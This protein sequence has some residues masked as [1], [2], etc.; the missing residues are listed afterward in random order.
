MGEA[1]WSLQYS[2]R[3]GLAGCL[4]LIFGYVLKF[5]TS[6][7]DQLSC[8]VVYSLLFTVIALLN[9]IA[10][11]RLWH[12]STRGEGEMMWS[13]FTSL[14]RNTILNE[15]LLQISYLLPL[16]HI[17]FVAFSL[18]NVMSRDTSHT[19]ATPKMLL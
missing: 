16:M 3:V 6:K 13:I 18:D 4:Y 2:I 5:H 15:V 12:I 7:R 17:K 9:L 19:L 14:Q 11:T 1:D 10:F 8:G